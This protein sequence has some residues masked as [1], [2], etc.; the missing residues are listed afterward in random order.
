MQWK[1]LKNYIP[2][3]LSVFYF[4][5]FPINIFLS[6]T[7]MLTEKSPIRLNTKII[8]LYSAAKTVLP[9][10]HEIESSFRAS[11]RTSCRFRLPLPL[12]FQFLLWTWIIHKAGLCILK[13]LTLNR[14]SENEQARRP[15]T[16]CRH[17]LRV[18]SSESYLVHHFL[19][20]S[21]DSSTFLPIF[22]NK[23]NR[24]RTQKMLF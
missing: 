21:R 11:T 12:L 13:N 7:E 20:V 10:S 24:D 18:N 19:E 2:K 23:Y 6:S 17:R 16:I 14:L 15:C 4:K 22:R 5:S 8:P 3:R 1:L 9:T